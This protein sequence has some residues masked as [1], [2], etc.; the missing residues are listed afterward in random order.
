MT[1]I[2]PAVRPFEPIRLIAEAVNVALRAGLTVS[3]VPALGVHC[4]STAKPRWEP[5]A[6]VQVIS[7][8]GA[9]LLARQPPIPDADAALAH[10]LGVGRLYVVGFD[11]GCA[12]QSPSV[13]MS[14]GTAS[15]LYGDGFVAGAQFRAVM[16][17]RQAVPVERG[18]EVTGP[19]HV[20]ASRSVISELIASLTVAQVLTA[21]ADSIPGRGWGADDSADCTEELRAMADD[22]KSVRR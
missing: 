6:R 3:A 19:V 2:S 9:V 4:V 17:R 5:E 14:G 20:G 12:G 21:L 10:A 8:L 7:P 11:D 13:S 22:Y 15:R 18:A 16:H 1:D